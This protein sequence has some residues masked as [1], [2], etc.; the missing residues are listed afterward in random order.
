MAMCH[1]C[2]DDTEPWLESV[3]LTIGTPIR[4][5]ARYFKGLAPSPVAA[6][7][8]FIGY[9]DCVLIHLAGVT[10]ATR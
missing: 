6:R 10:S 3:A 4:L 5:L 9:G 7:H 2:Q 8:R 1:W